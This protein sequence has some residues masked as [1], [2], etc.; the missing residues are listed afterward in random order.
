MQH[1][2]WAIVPAVL[3]PYYI[4]MHGIVWAHLRRAAPAPALAS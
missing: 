2:P 4:V 1:M 3:V